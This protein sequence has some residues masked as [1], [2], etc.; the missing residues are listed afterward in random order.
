MLLYTVVLWPVALA[1]ALLGLTGIVYGVVALAASA[2]FTLAAIRVWY[3]DG[4]ASAKRMFAFSILYLFLLFAV[5]VVDRAPGL[6]GGL[7]AL[8]GVG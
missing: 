2:L 6:A 3:D 4:E 1:P 8:L 7:G 5:M